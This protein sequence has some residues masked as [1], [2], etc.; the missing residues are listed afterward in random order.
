MPTSVTTNDFFN[1]LRQRMS[2]YNAN[3]LLN[4]AIVETGLQVKKDDC[5]ESDDVK[6]LCLELIKK[7]GPSFYVGQAIYR[8][9]L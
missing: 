3:L 8:E 9:T 7:G 1:R 2:I 4:S 6:S 5:L